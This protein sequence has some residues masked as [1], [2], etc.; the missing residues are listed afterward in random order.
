MKQIIATGR[1]RQVNNA[2]LKVD[3]G[4]PDF[5]ELIFSF[6]YNAAVAINS[7]YVYIVD[8]YNLGHFEQS[9]NR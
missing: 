5:S 9:L 6:N 7:M 2:K 8:E 3:F 4:N 1:A